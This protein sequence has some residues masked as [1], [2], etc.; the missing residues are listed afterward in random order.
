MHSAESYEQV[1]LEAVGVSVAA[2]V[3][4]QYCSMS[5]V[6]SPWPQTGQAPKI[7]AEEYARDKI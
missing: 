5:D 2:V 6:L 1:A 4:H 7:G 3:Y